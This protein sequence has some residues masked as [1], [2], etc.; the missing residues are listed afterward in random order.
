MYGK[1]VI[2][3]FFKA[4]IACKDA[5]QTSKMFLKYGKDEPMKTLTSPTQFQILKR[6]LED[7]QYVCMFTIS[8]YIWTNRPVLTPEI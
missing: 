2:L 5:S 7:I 8:T 4:S 1:R 3:E 6:A